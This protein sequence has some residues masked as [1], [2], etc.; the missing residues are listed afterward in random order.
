MQSMQCLV[1]TAALRFMRSG[2]LQLFMSRP[3]ADSS[4]GLLL[5]WYH[6][7]WLGTKDGYMGYGAAMY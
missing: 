2:K 6:I 7:F 4:D 5:V 3:Q 1:I